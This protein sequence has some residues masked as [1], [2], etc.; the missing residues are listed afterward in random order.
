MGNETV[1]RQQNCLVNSILP[2]IFF[3]VSVELSFLGGELSLQVLKT[4]LSDLVSSFVGRF[5]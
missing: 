2:K 1:N 3:C 5:F 4:L